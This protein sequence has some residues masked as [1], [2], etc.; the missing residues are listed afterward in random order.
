MDAAADGARQ[1]ERYGVLLLAIVASF[2]LLGVGSQAAFVQTLAT[3]LLAGTVLLALWA[4]DVARPLALLTAVL[5]VLVVG[6]SV[7][8][9][10]GDIAGTG[11][12]RAATALLVALAPPAVVLG[13]VRSL[14]RHQTVTV[15]AVFGVLCLYLLLG[16]LFAFVFGAVDAIGGAPFFAQDVAA[17]SSRCLYFSFATLTTVGFGDLTARSNLGHTLAV[18]EALL[19]QIYLVTVVSVIVGNLRRRPEAR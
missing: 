15:E 10:L 16:M 14:R 18:F 13:V 17:T 12:T 19:G 2:A 8:D 5:A 7:A 1:R 6:A 4:A 9:A 3:A 11:P